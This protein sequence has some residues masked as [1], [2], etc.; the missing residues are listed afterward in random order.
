VRDAKLYVARV[1]TEV[2]LSVSADRER[3]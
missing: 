1:R 3:Q 2:R